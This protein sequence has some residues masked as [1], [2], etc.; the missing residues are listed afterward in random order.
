[1]AAKITPAQA[2]AKAFRAIRLSHDKAKHGASYMAKQYL[3]A[4]GASQ[5]E[6]SDAMK[7]MQPL[8][9]NWFAQRETNPAFTPNVAAT[10]T[11][12][13]VPQPEP[14]NALEAN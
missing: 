3:I 2:A 4:S 8:L 7:E 13:P 10:P 12:A 11:P 5:A 6:A 1:M 14:T 9:D